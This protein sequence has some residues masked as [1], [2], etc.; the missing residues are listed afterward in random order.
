[1]K[2]KGKLNYREL[3]IF[4]FLT[5]TA[6]AILA[7]C[8][9]NSFL[10]CF[11]EE[12]DVSCFFTTARS[13]LDGKVLYRDVYEQKGIYSYVFYMLA[14]LICNKGYLGAYIVEGICASVFLILSYKTA[15]LLIK[16]VNASVI[17]SVLTGIAAYTSSGMQEGGFI[18]EYMIPI[19][20]AIVFL[21]V[22]HYTSKQSEDFPIRYAVIIG[23]LSGIIFWIKYSTLGIVIGLAI[24]IAVMQIKNK[25]GKRLFAIVAA[26]LLGMVIAS[27]PALIYFIKTGSFGDMI[28]VYFYNL[29]FVY[30]SQH[31]DHSGIGN[32]RDVF[33]SN[34]QLFVATGGLGTV[35]FLIGSLWYSRDKEIYLNKTGRL[36]ILSM[37]AGTFIFL[38]YGI[39]YGSCY[40]VLAMM[41]F[42]TI[43]FAGMYAYLRG[44][45]DGEKSRSKGGELSFGSIKTY[46]L[47]VIA[48]VC[49]MYMLGIFQGGMKVIAIILLSCGGMA[50]CEFA[51]RKTKNK[52]KGYIVKYTLIVLLII[53]ISLLSILFDK[54]SIKTLKALSDDNMIACALIILLAVEAVIDYRAD[55]S[56]FAKYAEKLGSQFLSRKRQLFWMLIVLVAASVACFFKSRNVSYMSKQYEETTVYKFA[57]YIREKNIENPTIIHIE[58]I[59][60]GIY[61]ELGILPNVKFFGDYSVELPEIDEFLEEYV[62]GKKADFLIVDNTVLEWNDENKRKKIKE[63]LSG[64][65]VVK[66]GVVDNTGAYVYFL[67]EKQE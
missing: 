43:G 48:L 53:F 60:S 52:E 44:F 47:A 67:Y 8:S 5:V 46:A 35:V 33:V 42:A 57:Q 31:S 27:L 36:A 10:Y 4:A 30:G 20:A 59:D 49:I 56:V 15:F 3:G 25:R 41:P 2:V 54:T 29:I 55:K 24:F 39:L 45:G 37:F 1:M 51:R 61:S 21:G 18:E 17:I 32:F 38:V 65:K 28:H 7:I 40:Q 11:N 23:I 12:P 58:T 6:F 22:K 14:Y 62:K 16:R 9:E 13:M 50:I 66:S 64:Y 19:F 26:F 34:K 63:L